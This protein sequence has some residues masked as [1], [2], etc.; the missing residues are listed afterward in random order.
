MKQPMPR[1]T[2][3]ES[4]SALKKLKSDPT[5]LKKLESLPAAWK[6]LAPIL[7]IE[8]AYIDIT[9]FTDA[10]KKKFGKAVSDLGRAVQQILKL[11]R[12]NEARRD[13]EDKLIAQIR[14]ACNAYALA[15]EIHPLAAQHR[16]GRK[17]TVKAQKA[18]R[19]ESEPGR[20]LVYKRL[21]QLIA[22]DPDWL[23][24]PVNRIATHIQ[25]DID[26]AI[27]KLD[28]ADRPQLGPSNVRKHV[29]TYLAEHTPEHKPT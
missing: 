26:K 17:Q 24:K 14:L 28:P 7:A 22:E 13:N 11:F 5:A 25:P 6:I 20:K 23:G 15:L 12:G 1:V 27:E 19:A 18:R 9:P 10:E 29:K 3:P 21:D 8:P 4:L 16:R 2:D